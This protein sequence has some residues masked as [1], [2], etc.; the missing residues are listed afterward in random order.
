[1]ESY[2]DRRTCRWGGEASRLM[3][4]RTRIFSTVSSAL[5]YLNAIPRYL[6]V[7]WAHHRVGVSLTYPVE[8]EFLL[9]QVEEAERER[10]GGGGTTR[11]KVV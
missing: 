4:L 10:G 8:S 9:H 5:S 3:G 2:R 11:V 6:T 1:M 7:V